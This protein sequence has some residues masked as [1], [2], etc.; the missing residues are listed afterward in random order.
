MQRYKYLFSK[1]ALKKTGMPES[2]YCL[3]ENILEAFQEND[4]AVFLEKISA[5]EKYLDLRS[6]FQKLDADLTLQ[7]FIEK[8]LSG[9][10]TVSQAC[11]IETYE[12]GIL[13]LLNLSSLKFSLAGTSAKSKNLR[14]IK[15]YV[16]KRFFE[17]RNRNPDIKANA[18]AHLV[19]QEVLD[20]FP[21]T[22]L[23]K[24]NITGCLNKWFSQIKKKGSIV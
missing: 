1:K 20:K 10:Y 8:H 19:A 12:L 17:E 5:S 18:I 13:C 9:K 16:Q 22:T 15:E 14:P 21:N 6:F 3:L 24:A 23:S 4:A 7:R 2:F 11:F